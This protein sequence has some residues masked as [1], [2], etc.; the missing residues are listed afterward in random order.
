MGFVRTSRTE[1]A[2]CSTALP[3]F[4]VRFHMIAPHKAGCL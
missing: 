2:V 1:C 3:S 4:A